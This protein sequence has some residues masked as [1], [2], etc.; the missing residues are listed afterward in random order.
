MA[1]LVR[2]FP[3]SY[4]PPL[5]SCQIATAPIGI[6]RASVDSD[7][8]KTTCP[9]ENR[10]SHSARSQSLLALLYSFNYVLHIFI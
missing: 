5:C 3:S 7:G 1:V 4:V 6:P 9:T 8:K 2:D 10:S